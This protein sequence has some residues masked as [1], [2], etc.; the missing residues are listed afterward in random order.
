M[1][2]ATL[3]KIAVPLTQGQFSTHYGRTTAFALFDVDL[4]MAKVLAHSIVPVPG[5]HACGMASWLKS[6][7][8]SAVIV[9]GIGG[10]AVANLQAAQIQVLAATGAAEPAELVQACLQESLPA[11]T[12]NCEHRHEDGQGHGDSCHCSSTSE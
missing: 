6:Q 2:Q 1:T 5:A 10:G 4:P 8:V 12:A 3:T 7:G 9:G 11:A